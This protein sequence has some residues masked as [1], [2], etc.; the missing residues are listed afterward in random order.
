MMNTPYDII[1]YKKMKPHDPLIEFIPKCF[2]MELPKIDLYS[3]KI[4]SYKSDISS[5]NSSLKTITSSK[6]S[7]DLP[8]LDCAY[9]YTASLSSAAINGILFSKKRYC[10]NKHGELG[11]ICPMD[12]N[13]YGEFQSTD[14]HINGIKTYCSVC[15]NNKNKKRNYNVYM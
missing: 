8:K 5:K 6:S 14:Y 11:F 13:R 12:K 2:I 7:G 1:F 9:C 15:F 10:E 3:P 4:S